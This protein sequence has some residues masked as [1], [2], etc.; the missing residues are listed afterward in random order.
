MT[1]RIIKVGFDLDGVL[2]YNPT[3]VAR[4][5]IAKIKKLIGRDLNKFY[6]PKSRFEKF[7]WY[8]VHK[9]SLFPA[10]GV[11]K[12][13]VLIKSKKIK[14]Y[15]ISARYE[16][17]KNDFDSWIKQVDPNKNFSGYFFNDVNDQPQIFKEKMIRKLDLDVFV[18]DNWD[19]VS[20]LN[21]RLKHRGL[22]IFWIY[23][24]FDKKIKYRYKFP[25]LLKA[26]DN[27]L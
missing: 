6:Y 4:P 10:E 8:L 1:K 26:L 19:I 11:E 9:S 12:I 5:V 18:E 2:L 3:R 24:L 17:F 27:L 15:V 13:Q 23:N 22:K 25:S 14:V 16:L 20:H 21:T 7:F